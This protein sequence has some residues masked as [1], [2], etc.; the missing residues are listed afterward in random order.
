M[1]DVTAFLANPSTYGPSCT[2]VERVETHISVIFLAGDRALKLKRA[3]RL[4]YLDYSTLNARR[5]CCEKEVA[6]NQRTAPSL[7]RGV[8][9]V[10]R[11]PDGTLSLGG[12]GVPVEWLVDMRRFDQRDQLDEV[13]RRGALDLTV[14]AALGAAA[15]RLHLAAEPRPDRGGARA[16]QWIVDENDSE[17]AAAEPLIERTRRARVHAACKDV[18]DAQRELLD[19]RRNA[20]W[21]RQCHGDLHL[22][23]IYLD[24][25]RP[26]LFDGIE[27]NDDLS[28]IDVM[29]DVA[30]LVMDLV[31]RGLPAHAHAA[32]G[33]WLDALPHYDALPLLPLFLACRAAIRSKVSLTAAALTAD[34]E[35]ATHLH[36]DAR[37]YLDRALEFLAPPGGR[38][39]AIG[40]WSGTGKS[41][42]ARALA[43]ELGRSPG[44]VVLR[45]DVFRKRRFGVDPTT[46]LPASAYAAAASR[47]VYDDVLQA[48]QAVARAG[49]V[50]IVDAVCG[51]T[52]QRKAIREAAAAAGVP[53]TG[54]WLHASESVLVTRLEQRSLDASDATAEVL[55]H[56][57]QHLNGPEDWARIDSS[58]PLERVIAAVHAALDTPGAAA[59]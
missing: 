19:A 53:F 29:Y 32:M 44:A 14:A 54:V 4:P 50:A 31:D 11:Q 51:E 28:C 39:V 43:P 15:A 17:L 24:H 27:F 1:S 20:G 9:A 5:A 38:I 59:E 55:R 34:A 7:Y 13:A 26:V 25:G 35:R 41:T 2:H 8:T 36:A 46:R 40:G 52:W 12:T 56:Q 6:L 33:A 21:V 18:L 49:Y 48:A 57:Q 37:A 30:F 42:V 16:M 58:A 3:V 23:N 22:G 10:T 45:S 47:A